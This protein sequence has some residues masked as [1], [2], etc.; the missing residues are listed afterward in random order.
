MNDH[1]DLFPGKRMV[2]TISGIP[3]PF[4]YCPSGKFVMGSPESELNRVENERQHNV[5]L[6]RGFWLLETLVSQ[7]MWRVVMGN[8]PSEARGDDLPVEHVSWYDCRQ[9]VEKLNELNVAPKGLRFDLPTEAQGEYAFRAGRAAPYPSG[10]ALGVSDA[11]IDA[12]ELGGVYLGHTTEVER[13]PS[14]AWGFR[15]VCG[16]VW[17]WRRDWFGEFP[18][19]DAVDPT[20]P[21]KGD[22]KS[23]RGGSWHSTPGRCRIAFR[24]K[25]PPEHRHGY[26]GLRIALVSDAG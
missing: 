14:N 15:D 26:L 1:L 11:N 9:F 13:Y 8:Q 25:D 3:F 5:T 17:E 7:T 2:L 16:N 21:E 19:G 18:E 24:H 6:T 12:R 20:G 10:E 23:L 4:R 22:F